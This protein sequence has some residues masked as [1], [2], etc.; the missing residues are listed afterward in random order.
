MKSENND[1]SLIHY[2]HTSTAKNITHGVRLKGHVMTVSWS[3]DNSEKSINLLA[4]RGTLVPP[5][6]RGDSDRKVKGNM[7]EDE[8]KRVKLLNHRDT[9]RN[10][11]CTVSRNEV[12]LRYTI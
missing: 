4:M 5:V 10:T 11:N 12:N 6:N 8:E 3:S 2:Q 9:G 1:F 7:L